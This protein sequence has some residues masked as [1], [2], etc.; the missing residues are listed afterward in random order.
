[1][2]LALCKSQVDARGLRLG[3]PEGGAEASVLGTKSS[4]AENAG[5]V[6]LCC[7]R[8]ESK[9]VKKLELSSR[10]SLL[11]RGSSFVLDCI[12]ASAVRASCLSA[13]RLR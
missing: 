5:G 10:A 8:H 11:K 7:C 1:M 6:R 4:S 9:P 12:S 2:R 13:A 3:V